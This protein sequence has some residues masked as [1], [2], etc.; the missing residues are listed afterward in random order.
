MSAVVDDDTRETLSGR[1]DVRREN[2][3]CV[4]Q[5]AGNAW[6]WC[7]AAEAV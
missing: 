6:T 5:V 7:L 2:P 1:Q 3:R 4:G